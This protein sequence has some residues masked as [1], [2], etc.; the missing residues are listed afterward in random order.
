MFPVYAVCK[1]LS[2]YQPRKVYPF[3]RDGAGIAAPCFI[4]S[5]FGSVPS[6]FPAVRYVLHVHTDTRSPEPFRLRSVRSV[7]VE[8]RILR[9]CVLPVSPH[10]P[11]CLTE[12][13][14]MQP[15]SRHR[16]R[17]AGCI[18][19]SNTLLSVPICVNR[20]VLGRNCS[21][22]YFRKTCILIPAIEGIAFPLRYLFHPGSVKV[23]LFGRRISVICHHGYLIGITPVAVGDGIRIIGNGQRTALFFRC[24]K[25]SI[26]LYFRF[27]ILCQEKVQIKNDFFHLASILSRQ[28]FAPALI[29]YSC[30]VFILIRRKISTMT[31]NPYCI[32]K[33][34][35]VL[36]NKAVCM[37]I[38]KYFKAV[39][40]FSF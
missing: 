1:V 12:I 36:K 8:I 3:R 5:C 38:I 28:V 11:S 7:A 29:V 13:P 30:I 16:L 32:I 33:C 27:L 40:P 23:C 6:L 25:S 37:F 20:T 34:L 39:Q 31:M 14:W 21:V 2:V 4:C 17:S 10:L 35:Y 15:Y 18:L 22:K 9:T 19:P 26:R 24:G